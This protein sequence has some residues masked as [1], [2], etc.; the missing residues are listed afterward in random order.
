MSGFMK[1]VAKRLRDSQASQGDHPSAE[2]LCSFAAGNASTAE[3]TATLQHLSQCSECR[4]LLHLMT[5]AEREAMKPRAA[6]NGTGM[7]VNL[8]ALRACAGA[9]VAAILILMPWHNIVGTVSVAHRGTA[10]TTTSSTHERSERERALVAQAEPEVRIH[11]SPRPSPRVQKS[12]AMPKRA[13]LLQQPLIQPTVPM[14]LDLPAPPAM[15][16]QQTALTM[17]NQEPEAPGRH[18]SFIPQQPDRTLLSRSLLAERQRAKPFAQ[19]ISGSQ[20]ASSSWKL[21]SPGKT[22]SGDE[23]G[24]LLRSSD[25]GVTWEQVTV[26]GETPLYALSATGADVWAG[27]AGGRLFHSVDDGLHWSEVRIARDGAVITGTITTIETN[28]QDLVFVKTM[29]GERWQ[30]NDGGAHWVRR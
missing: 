18:A 3:R 4:E 11:R 19:M 6:R 20:I 21:V 9:A 13:A 27:G 2:L 7:P 25:Q 10:G 30:S 23:S 22:P 15:E 8:W 26:D 29:A 1:F 12:S 5:A 17:A 28:N 14:E 24:I 16:P